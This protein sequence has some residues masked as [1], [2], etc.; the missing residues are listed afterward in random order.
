[1][2]KASDELLRRESERATSSGSRRHTTTVASGTTQSQNGRV[3]ELRGS[4]QPHGSRPVKVVTSCAASSRRR[5]NRGELSQ[6]DGGS[7]GRSHAPPNSPSSR[8]FS[9]TNRAFSQ[10]PS[11][12]SAAGDSRSSSG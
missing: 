2:P 3:S 7:G 8:S 6:P 9:F 4:F 10:K 12:L 11:G 5:D 1:M